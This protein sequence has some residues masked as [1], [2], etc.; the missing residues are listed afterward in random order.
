MH[1]LA[2][3]NQA[4]MCV[5]IKAILCSIQYC[6]PF[7]VHRIHVVCEQVDISMTLKTCN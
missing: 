5:I 4:S 2:L 3:L 7:Q 6:V 1:H